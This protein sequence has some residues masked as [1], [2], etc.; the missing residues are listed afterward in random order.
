VVL[1]ENLLGD[2]EQVF[3]SFRN[4]GDFQLEFGQPVVQIMRKRPE[5]TSSSRS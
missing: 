1:V 4:G 5:R 3:R 2:C